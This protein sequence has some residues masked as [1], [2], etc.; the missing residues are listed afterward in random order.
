MLLLVGRGSGSQHLAILFR[1]DIAIRQAHSGIGDQL[2]EPQPCSS[3]DSALVSSVAGAK[4]G[5]AGLGF[6][7]L[8]R[9]G[10]AKEKEHARVLVLERHCCKC[11]QAPLLFA[12]G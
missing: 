12:G 4:E 1:A 10:K 5:S 2:P 9:G 6:A 7:L 8:P 3:R 11:G